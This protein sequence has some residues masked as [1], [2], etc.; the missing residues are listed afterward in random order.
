M[1]GAVLAAS[2]IRSASSSVG[3]GV[4]LIRRLSAKVTIEFAEVGVVGSA[5]DPAAVLRMKECMV[6]ICW[7]LTFWQGWWLQRARY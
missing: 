5:E 2:Q 6:L 4:R 7:Q 1:G 3:D